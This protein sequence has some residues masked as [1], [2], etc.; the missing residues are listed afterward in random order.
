MF[1]AV[2]AGAQGGSIRVWDMRSPAK[3][4]FAFDDAHRNAD[5]RDVMHVEFHHD[6][7]VGCVLTYGRLCVAG[8]P[9]LVQLR[10]LS[11][12]WLARSGCGPFS[13]VPPGPARAAAGH[14][15]QRL[16]GPHGGGVGP[17][18]Q[19]AGGRGGCA[20]GQA[21][22]GTLPLVAA[23]RPCRC[24]R[25]SPSRTLS[26][27]SLLV[28]RLSQLVSLSRLSAA[29]PLALPRCLSAAEHP[30]CLSRA[31]PTHRGRG[32]LS[33]ALAAE[34]RQGRARRAALPAATL[35]A[36]GPQAG[37]ERIGAT[38]ALL[39]SAHAA[40]LTRCQRRAAGPGLR[41]TRPDIVSI[42]TVRCGRH[43]RPQPPC[44]PWPPAPLPPRR[45]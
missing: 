21:G 43:M 3:P 44:P 19:R 4:L 35:P 37:G 33:Q 12:P 1:F 45:K 34:Q 39:P 9:W 8:R 11:L 16:R 7:P 13:S 18:P 32:R 31:A 5:D 42:A 36:P 10:E 25:R 22:K 23:T 38:T 20:W 27:A 14:L 30:P 17:Q 24:L 40:A 26:A 2:C 6:S 28:S 15:R 41:P 29:C